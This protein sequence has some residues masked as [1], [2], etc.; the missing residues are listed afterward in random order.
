MGSEASGKDW[1]FSET[2]P[3]AEVRKQLLPFTLAILTFLP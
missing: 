3:Y 2:T 1:S